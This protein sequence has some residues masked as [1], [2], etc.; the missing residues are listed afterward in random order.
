MHA[1]IEI[2]AVKRRP[3]VSRPAAIDTARWAQQGVP[4]GLLALPRFSPLMNS[5]AW[6]NCFSN[7]HAE[8]HVRTAFLSVGI[9]FEALLAGVVPLEAEHGHGLGLVMVDQP[10]INVE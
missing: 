8:E 4:I 5:R 9:R 2:A 10:A 7:Q 6:P 1:A 3:R